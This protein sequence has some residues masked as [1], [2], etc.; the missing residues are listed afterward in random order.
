MGLDYDHEWSRRYPARLVR[1][2]MLDN[3]TRPLAQL[4][5]PTTV[6]GREHLRHIEPPMIFVANHTS[7]I[8]TPLLLTTLPVELRHRTVVA[9]AS[10][11][12]FDRTWK[13]VLWSLSLAAIPIERSRVNR[14]SAD[15]AAELVEDG[16]NLVIF[17]EGGRS[18]DGWLQEFRGGAAYLAR[19]TGRP[20]VPVH[21]DGTRDVLAKD[22]ETADRPPGGS[23]TEGRLHGAPAPG[24]R[25]SDVRARPRAPG[26]GGRP[27]PGRP[28][29]T[30]RLGARRGG[31]ERLVDGEAPAGRGG[32]TRP[33]G[34]GGLAVATCLGPR[35]PA[36]AGPGGTPAA[37]GG[38]GPAASLATAGTGGAVGAAGHRAPGLEDGGGRT[39]GR[40]DDG[41]WPNE[42]TRDPG[43]RRGRRSWRP[44]ESRAPPGGEG[45]RLVD[46]PDRAL[47]RPRCSPTRAPT[48]IK[49]ERPG[50]GDIARWVGVRVNGMSSLYLV[51]N[52]GKRS[53]AVDL[54]N[55]EG[56]D[57]VRR[58]AAERRRAS[59][60]TSGRA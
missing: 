48:S 37:V 19:R 50:I 23:G 5:V 32:V 60:R 9:A 45:R 4:V 18:P 2:A 20:V 57:I 44:G 12:F 10:D 38:A 22:P 17:P 25:H 39:S 46:R 55:A 40:V 59:S 49:V 56:V 14:R 7:H 8:D 16:W 29:R 34:A 36:A 1:A 42:R 21:I 43:S 28:D 24:A 52:R 26:G 35:T 31:P 27:P 6:R 51:C 53:I 30:G 58:L 47:R 15:T 3:L 13:S 54:H 11:Y 41:S 33:P